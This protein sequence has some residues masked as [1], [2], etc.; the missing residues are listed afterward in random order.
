MSY[1]III[2]GGG[3]AGLTSAAFLCKNGYKVLLCEKEG[4]L[5]GLVNSFEYKGFIFDGGIRALE[6]SGIVTPMLKQL[7]IDIEFL[8]NK[9]SVGIEDEVLRLKSK[10]SL[11]DYQQM[12]NHQFPDNIDDI[13][14][15]IDEIKKIMKYMDVLY[16]IDNPLFLDFKQDREYMLKTIVPWLFK[17]ITT[18]NKILKLNTPIYEYMRKFTDN[19]VLIDIISQHFFNKTPASFALSYFSLYLDYRYPKGGTGTLPSKMSEYISNNGCEVRLNTEIKAVDSERR[20]VTDTDGNVFSYNKLIWTGDSRRLYNVVDIDSIADSKIRGKVAAQKEYL[21]DKVGGDSVLTLYATVDE[22]KSY[23]DKIAS[24]HFFYTPYKKGLSNIKIESLSDGTGAYPKLKY[25]EDKKAIFT[26]IRQFL[27]LTS[28]EIS[29]P[30]L[31]DPD[32]A[33]EGK[34]GLIISTLFEH[35]IVKHIADMGWYD[36]FKEICR[37]SIIEALG[38]TIYPAL[39]DRLID[40]FM[41]TPLTIEKLTGNSNGAITGW[42]FTNSS[43]PALT[44]LP[45]VA[46]SANTPIPNVLQAGQ[47][48]F[49]P[50]GLPISILT[51]KLAADKAGK[52]IK[53]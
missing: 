7:G 16:G 28:Y 26:W 4:K 32:M 50:S 3:I 31:R 20:T 29:I 35:S 53:K 6:N 36:E 13:S 39:K 12:L 44:N 9:I 22:V 10:E 49:S 8:E 48:S 38:G 40:S 23:F 25:I 43:M 18:V 21:S 5:G 15:I 47:W 30:V 34:T 45:K 17:Y 2:V 11:M 1:D 51:G 41:S 14:R 33:P 27:E 52:G 19:T 46:Q 42:A 37:Q 24:G